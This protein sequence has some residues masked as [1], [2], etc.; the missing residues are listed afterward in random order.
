MKKDNRQVIMV[1][2]IRA[3]YVLQEKLQIETKINIGVNL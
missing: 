3:K 2:I 1:F